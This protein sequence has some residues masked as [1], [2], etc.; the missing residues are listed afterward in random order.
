ML[1]AVKFSPL[2]KD[3]KFVGFWI[4]LG[5]KRISS[6][7]PCGDDLMVMSISMI[8]LLDFISWFV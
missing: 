1:I 4:I 6:L 2:E 5:G 7:R 8:F 3:F